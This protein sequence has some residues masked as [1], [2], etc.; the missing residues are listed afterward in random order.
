MTKIQ[1]SK[2]GASTGDRVSVIGAW[3][4]GFVWNLVLGIS[5]LFSVDASDLESGL[6]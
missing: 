4:F 6:A 2:P 3:V 1:N 5:N